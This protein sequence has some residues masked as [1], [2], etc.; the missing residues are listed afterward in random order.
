MIK[1]LLSSLFIPLCLF[2][3]GAST[4]QAECKPWPQNQCGDRCGNFDNCSGQ[5]PGPA[6]ACIDKHSW[7]SANN[8]CQYN[9]SYWQSPNSCPADSS[10]NKAI[11][12][13]G[14]VF[15]CDGSPKAGVRVRSLGNTAT[16]NAQGQFFI[17]KGTSVG[18]PSVE[19]LAGIDAG[20]S[21]YYTRIDNPSFNRGGN[22]SLIN[23]NYSAGLVAGGPA[24]EAYIAHGLADHIYEQ[25]LYTNSSTEF[26]QNFDFKEV[27]CPTPPPQSQLQPPT[28]SKNNWPTSISAT[29]TGTFS[30]A[31]ADPDSVSGAT[32]PNVEF[33]FTKQLTNY[34]IANPSTGSAVNG[35]W[36]KLGETHTGSLSTSRTLNNATL[37]LPAGT[38]K[39]TTNL[40]DNDN[41]F[42]TGN[43]GTPQGCGFTYNGC[44]GTFTIGSVPSPTPSRIPT[45][46]PPGPTITSPPG[47]TPSPT[48]TPPAQPPFSVQVNIWEGTNCSNTSTPVVSPFA[49]AIVAKLNSQSSGTNHAITHSLAVPGLIPG[50]TSTFSLTNLPTGWSRSSCSSGTVSR[51]HFSQGPVDFHV[52]RAAGPWWQSAAGDIY[53]FVVES[54][55]PAISNGFLTL[56][57]GLTDPGVFLWG[58]S[59]N[60]PENQ[61]RETN[62]ILKAKTNPSLKETYAYFEQLTRDFEKVV[63]A[64][65]TLPP[66]PTMTPNRQATLLKKS[67]NLELNSSWG[68][69]RKLV[70]FVDGNLKINANQSVPVGSYLQ[71]IVKGGITI[72]GSVTEVQGMYSADGPILI[73]ASANKFI[74][75]GS[76]VSFGAGGIES[77]RSLPGADNNMQAATVFEFRP[78]LVINTPRELRRTDST[79]SE[80]APD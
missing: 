13:A 42:S 25:L 49:A 3:A 31:G 39:M 53:G 30:V 8:C 11:R 20:G 12:I 23:C 41:Q 14:R 4:I 78:D 66:L 63:I 10:E 32:T 37:N 22:C 15:A 56:K 71:F 73:E 76:M 57:R 27:N 46:T 64:G 52:E 59:H 50:E 55:L 2:M 19:V 75:R 18:H 9:G 5:R 74:S 54:A 69:G 67:G 28:C 48:L 21:G 45:V 47:A 35:K 70:V 43:P 62:P 51:Q 17:T 34:C 77:R 68:S 80:I 29:G 65:N 6:H 36:Q 16:T 38:Y 33:Y 72:A 26:L 40:R 60:I 24:R 61:I 7:D 1:R 44:Q 58:N 79:W